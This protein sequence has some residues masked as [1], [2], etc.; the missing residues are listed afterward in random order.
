MVIV[1]C[2]SP[3]P[4]ERSGSP[5][6]PEQSLGRVY[7]EW[8]LVRGR[9]VSA[10]RGT[11]KTVPWHMSLSVLASSCPGLRS[12]GSWLRMALYGTQTEPVFPF[13]TLRPSCFRWFTLGWGVGMKK[14]EKEG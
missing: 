8:G 2:G 5:W 11:L 12:H 3:G 10:W 9:L 14:E 4:L 1:S 13:W 6:H 7:M